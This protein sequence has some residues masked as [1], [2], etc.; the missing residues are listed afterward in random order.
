ML[1][2]PSLTPGRAPI[3]LPLHHWRLAHSEGAAVIKK[4]PADDG[5]V[6]VTKEAVSCRSCQ[7]QV[8]TIRRYDE[9]L[10][11]IT[12]PCSCELGATGSVVVHAPRPSK[13]ERGAQ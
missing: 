13:N 8:A 5:S 1:I 9:A 3:G 4:T 7:K 10:F 12:I 2:C 6:P 11:S